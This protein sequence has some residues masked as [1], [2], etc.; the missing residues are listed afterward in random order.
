MAIESINVPASFEASNN[1]VTP[2][3]TMKSVQ[4]KQPRLAK[5]P[6]NRIVNLR[7]K[8]T[9]HR[10]TDDGLPDALAQGHG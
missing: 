4:T 9:D 1:T 3:M 5:Q 6:K 7:R 10:Q 8:C 2:R